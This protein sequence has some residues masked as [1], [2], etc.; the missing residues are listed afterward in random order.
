VDLA[1]EKERLVLSGVR[2]L[3]SVGGGGPGKRVLTVKRGQVSLVSSVLAGS[4]V[5]T[6]TSATVTLVNSRIAIPAAASAMQAGTAVLGSEDRY[7]EVPVTH[8]LCEKSGEVGVAVLDG[9]RL[10]SIGLDVSGEMRVGVCV[11]GGEAHLCGGS[12]H[13]TNWD[14]TEVETGWGAY[15]GDGGELELKAVDVADNND[16]GILAEGE[17]TSLLVRDGTEVTRTAGGYVT[18][19]AGMGVVVQDN[20]EL[21][22]Q[23]SSVVDVK[24][25]GVVLSWG[26]SA[27]VTDSLFQDDEYSAFV[28]LGATLNLSG[29]SILGTGINCNMLGGWGVH[30]S[31][32]PYGASTVA[33][34]DTRID[35]QGV[36]NSGILVMGTGPEPSTVSVSASTIQGMAGE[37]FGSHTKMGAGF[38][39]FEA[40]QGITL[41]GNTYKGNV[42]PQIFL[43]G[44]DAAISGETIATNGNLDVLQ[45]DCTCATASLDEASL[46]AGQKVPLVL[47]LCD[48]DAYWEPFED[49]H[50]TILLEI[51]TIEG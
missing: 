51:A 14:Y 18:L 12:L 1:D 2:L 23:D 8:G 46:Q 49:D 24:G 40:C 6:G 30:V 16:V 22:F 15:V 38:Y 19:M 37:P 11:S 39:A 20:A 35:G 48:E 34:N 28:V 3:P 17:G 5:A 44:S 32:D 27:T 31:N 7:N 4:F 43:H 13:D 9:A 21:V 42:G 36:T 47:R 41:S 29:S 50:F 45:Q 25:P 33:I 10:Y 26:A